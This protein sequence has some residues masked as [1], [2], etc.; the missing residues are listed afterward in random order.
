MERR[1]LGRTGLEVPV[2]GF[3]CGAVGGL[4][5]RGAPQ[6]RERAVARALALGVDLFDTAPL[7]GQGLSETHLGEALRALRPR[8]HVAT[9]VRLAP[10]DLADVRG[11]VARSLEA[12]LRRLGRDRVDLLQLHNP[13]G[14]GWGGDA[15]PEA[16]VRDEVLP[17]LAAVRTAGTARFVGMTALG[18]TAVLHR[19]VDAGVLDTVQVVY[20]L[21]NPSAGRA[22]PAGAPGH[23]FGRL[24]DRAHLRGVGVIVV[25]VLAGGA[26]AGTADRH[27]VALPAVDPIASGPDYGTDVARAR[28]LGWLVTEGHAGSLVEA[29]IRFPLASPA[30][31][32]V[33]VGVSSLEQLEAAA[34]AVARGPL[35]PAVMARLGARPAGGPT[36]P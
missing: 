15:L 32:T 27:P 24:L 13:V 20:N 16:V 3:G 14:L 18:E 30:V 17:A 4:M 23:D 25:R 2:L 19:L 21:L 26:L 11:A 31:S 22:L 33:L 5:V 29:A 34:A 7:Y 10:G 9:K 12:S 28:A 6:E 1:R 8:C 35:P 36:G